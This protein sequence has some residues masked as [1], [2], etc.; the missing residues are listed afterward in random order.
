MPSAMFDWLGQRRLSVRFPLLLSVVWA[1]IS[2]VISV[3]CS[4]KYP[5]ESALGTQCANLCD[6]GGYGRDKAA[7]G[8][9][10]RAAVGQTRR[11]Q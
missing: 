2:M 3:G 1:T 9:E 6:Q 8:H 11:W 7:G 10:I 5:G 4:G